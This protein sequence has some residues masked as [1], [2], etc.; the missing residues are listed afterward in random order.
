[1]SYYIFKSYQAFIR[2]FRKCGQFSDSLSE[3]DYLNYRL[4]TYAVGTSKLTIDSFMLEVSREFRTST[5]QIL[6]AYRQLSRAGFY[7]KM[8]DVAANTVPDAK[9]LN[10]YGDGEI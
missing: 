7:S 5:S 1:M 9:V 6:E 10:F 2:D 4:F 3:I 8:Y